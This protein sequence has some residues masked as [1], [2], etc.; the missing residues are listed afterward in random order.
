MSGSQQ[1]QAQVPPP[2]PA[3]AAPV[4]DPDTTLAQIKKSLQDNQAQI[5]GLAKTRDALSTRAGTL[6]QSVDDGKK[7][8]AAYTA[9]FPGLD[10]D[11]TSLVTYD[12]AKMNFVQ[13]KLAKERLAQVDS[14][15]K[16]YDDGLAARKADVDKLTKA[17]ADARGESD[18]ARADLK[19]AQDEYSSL[20]A[21]QKGLADK[22]SASKKL[23]AEIDGYEAKKNYE[24]M[25]F[26]L[27][28]AL[29]P[30]A[31]D[32]HGSILSVDA[33]KKDVNTVVIDLDD[34]WQT[35]QAKK[36]AADAADAQAAAAKAAY[37]ALVAGRNAEVLKQIAALPPALPAS[38]PPPPPASP[39]PP[40]VA[41]LPP[42]Q[43]SQA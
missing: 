10:A 12:Q 34:T 25:Y 39:P 40:Q 28:D 14:I 38:P 13:V 33:F 32:F 31:N 3:A 11:A 27:K 6:G 41:T 5:D 16:A 17:A 7:T 35:A 20:K 2:P 36:Q 8:L 30:A 19:A 1:T 26:R 23:M 4:P 22:D 21:L 15:V 37:D 18:K 29:E 24:A 9:A 42:P 43:T